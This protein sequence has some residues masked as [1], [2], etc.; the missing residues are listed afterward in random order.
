MWVGVGPQNQPSLV[1]GGAP[2]WNMTVQNQNLT[3][4]FRSRYF[5]SFLGSSTEPP[6]GRPQP[7]DGQMSRDPGEPQAEE[8]ANGPQAYVLERCGQFLWP[9][10]GILDVSSHPL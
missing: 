5:C 6:G 4:P 8:V 2:V 1:G 7:A 10:E 9:Q 3:H